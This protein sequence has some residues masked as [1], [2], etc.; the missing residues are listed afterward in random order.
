[1][2][3]ELDFTESEMIS[4]ISTK[5]YSVEKEKRT[6]D[7]TNIFS[8]GTEEL[9]KEVIIVY[10]HKFH[11]ES[12]NSKYLYSEIKIPDEKNFQAKSSVLKEIFIKELKKSLL[13][14]K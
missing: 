2:K 3:I 8:I 14:L 10:E 11:F 12:D 7:F 13:Q 4:F 5:N 9:E 6:F 1:M